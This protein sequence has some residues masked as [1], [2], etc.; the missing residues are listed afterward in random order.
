MS[1]GVEKYKIK[2]LADSMLD[3][4][5]LLSSQMTL[6]HFSHGVEKAQQLS[7]FFRKIPIQHDLNIPHGV[8]S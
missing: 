2:A 6:S 5:L 7:G 8:T 3:Q 4:I 1:A